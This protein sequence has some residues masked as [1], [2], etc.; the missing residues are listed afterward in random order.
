MTTAL[1]PIVLVLKTFS[2]KELPQRQVYTLEVVI[3]TSAE[4]SWQSSLKT[5]QL[6]SLLMTTT[7]QTNPD[8]L[9]RGNLQLTT[10]TTIIWI[11]TIIA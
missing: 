9:S 10:K 6:N 4:K 7:Y 3:V 5:I 8:N 2:I 11:L 1:T